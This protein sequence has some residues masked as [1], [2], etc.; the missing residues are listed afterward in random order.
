[1]ADQAVTT[2]EVADAIARVDA[3]LLEAERQGRPFVRVT[4]GDLVLVMRWAATLARREYARQTGRPW[5][6]ANPEVPRG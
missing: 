6:P 5:E 4:T 1:M 2:H 3:E